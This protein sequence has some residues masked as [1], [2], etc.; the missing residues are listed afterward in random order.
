MTSLDTLDV[1][2]IIVGE[3]S[4]EEMMGDED[5]LDVIPEETDQQRAHEFRLFKNL[6]PYKEQLKADKEKVA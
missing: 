6:P 2:V 1:N 3:F 4:D 5:D